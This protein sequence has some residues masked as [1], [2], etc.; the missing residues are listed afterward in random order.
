MAETQR[1]PFIRI[2]RPYGS[3]TE[4]LEGDFGWLGRTTVI[5]P[6]GPARAAGELVRFEI[7]LTSGAPILRGEGHVVAHHSPGGPRAPGLEV[8]FTRVDAKSKLLIDRVR[9]RRN[10]MSQP[11]SMSLLPSPSLLPMQSMVPSQRQ[12]SQELAAPTVPLSNGLPML[13]P[14][15]TWEGPGGTR[16]A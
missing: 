12:P 8:R 11:G 14:S 7:V 2:T 13:K 9:E 1:I 16:A 3:E 10:A 6:N 4:F 15:T 5:L